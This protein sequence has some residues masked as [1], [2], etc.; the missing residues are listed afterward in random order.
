MGTGGF[1]GICQSTT[2][3]I[4]DDQS[5]YH[6]FDGMFFV[7]FGEDF[8]VQIVKNTVHPDTGEAALAG[9]L[10]DLLVFALLAPDNR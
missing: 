10:K 8:L 7:L 3:T 2:L 6:Q 4:F 5:I 1:D 9:I